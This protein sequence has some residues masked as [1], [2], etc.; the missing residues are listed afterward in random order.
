M[1]AAVSFASVVRGPSVSELHLFW[2]LERFCFGR[3]ISSGREITNIK[4]L[5]REFPINIAYTQHR[6]QQMKINCENDVWNCW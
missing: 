6:Q 5:A 4:P 2:M 1:L 3:Q